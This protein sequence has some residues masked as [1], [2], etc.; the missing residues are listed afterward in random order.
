MPKERE[1]ALRENFHYFQGVVKSLMESHAGQ[2]ALLHSKSVIDIF[3][4]PI[5]ALQAGHT[6]FADGMFS[7][8][9]VTDRPFD[10]GFM[11]Y[12]SGERPTD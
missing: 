6:Q 9:K 5:E 4:R 12:G 7:V 10:L 2:Y 8:Q 11:S 1:T 3:P